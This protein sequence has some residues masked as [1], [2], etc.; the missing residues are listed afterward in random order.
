[1]FINLLLLKHKF[2][3]TLLIVKR[4][5]TR[6]RNNNLEHVQP[7][8]WRETT[9]MT[10]FAALLASVPANAD[11]HYGATQNGKQCFKWSP[12]FGREASFGYWD[13]CPKPASAA[14]APAA[15]RRAKR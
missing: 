11:M 5:A 9:K 1:M 14:T 8:N 12:G 2:S 4:H 13:T 7:D 15:T 10:A 6:S 3:I